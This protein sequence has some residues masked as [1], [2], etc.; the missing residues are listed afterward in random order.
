MKNRHVNTVIQE[1]SGCDPS[2][3]Y[4]CWDDESESMMCLRKQPKSNQTTATNKSNGEKGSTAMTTCKLP[5]ALWGVCEAG[6]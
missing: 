4:F 6:F 3:I 1:R 5:F 2:V